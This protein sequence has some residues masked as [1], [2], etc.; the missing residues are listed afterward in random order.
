[1]FW[2]ISSVEAANLFIKLS[3]LAGVSEAGA[4]RRNPER[5]EG[6][7]VLSCFSGPNAEIPS[8][9]RDLSHVCPAILSRLAGVSEAGARRRNPERSEGSS[10]L[11][12]FFRAQPRNPERSEGSLKLCSLSF[13]LI[14]LCR[15]MLTRPN[16]HLLVRCGKVW[17]TMCHTVA[18]V[19]S[20]RELSLA[21]L[22]A[23]GFL[24]CVRA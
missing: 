5:S 4:R 15:S 23:V 18:I 1:M 12:L 3:R 6:S 13:S 14:L 24:L 20:F 16:S 8:L 17:L 7:P 19:V 2:K 9:A 22:Y 21:C 10:V 11:F